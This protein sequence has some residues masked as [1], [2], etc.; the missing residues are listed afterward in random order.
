M[1]ATPVPEFMLEPAFNPNSDAGTSR[2]AV[3]LGSAAAKGLDVRHGTILT[4]EGINVSFDG[5]K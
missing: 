5:F 4:L 1:R 3:G 2:E